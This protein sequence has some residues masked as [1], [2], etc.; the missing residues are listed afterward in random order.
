MREICTSGAMRGEGS[1]GGHAGESLLYSIGSAGRS[2]Q[3][4]VGEEEDEHLDQQ[5]LPPGELDPGE[6]EVLRFGG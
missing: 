1:S 2:R 5:V 3:E 6:A 4:K